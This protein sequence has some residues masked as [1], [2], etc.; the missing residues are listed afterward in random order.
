MRL[1]DCRR[2]SARSRGRSSP[3]RGDSRKGALT[4]TG[5]Q[6][7]IAHLRAT[8]RVKPAD[9][10]CG[11]PP[12]LWT[13]G[14]TAVPNA[15]ASSGVDEVLGRLAVLGAEALSDRELVALVL[16]CEAGG[17]NALSQADALLDEYG[18]LRALSSARSEELDCRPGVDPASAAALVAAFELSRRISTH[19]PELLRC[20]AD[21]AAA[22]RPLLDGARQE[23]L[24]VLVCDAG[25]RLRRTIKVAEGAVD[26]SPVPVREI[27]NAVLRHDGRAFAVAH[28]HAS[29]QA[30]P[31][32]SDF[33]ATRAIK[34][35][36][37]VVGVRF[38]GHV[39]VTDCGWEAVA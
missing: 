31:S 10:R 9:R 22:V 27:L 35:A 28:N 16:R 19:Q 6:G 32:E 4:S 12:P 37:T 14:A 24:V 1:P 29:G 36:A 30:E 17:G 26:R 7:P 3:S 18:T 23:R 2:L 33:R 34:A 8:N 15:V 21:V 20:A 11:Y 38:L 5:R 13:T 39:I 25:N